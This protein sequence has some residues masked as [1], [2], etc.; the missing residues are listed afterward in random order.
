MEFDFFLKVLQDRFNMDG[1]YRC[2][3]LIFSDTR[4]NMKKMSD[5]HILVETDELKLTIE[6]AHSKID[7]NDESFA[8]NISYINL[9]RVVIV[10]EI[11]IIKD[12]NQLVKVVELLLLYFHVLVFEESK[13]LNITD[14]KVHTIQLE[15]VIINN[16]VFQVFC[17]PGTL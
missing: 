9:T 13:N 14:I 2:L 16:E 8:S 7:K 3:E 10:K 4:F 5:S 6:S 12:S 15:N 17:D 1:D 11:N